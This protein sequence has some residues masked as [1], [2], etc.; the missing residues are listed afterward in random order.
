[1]IAIL[2]ITSMFVSWAGG[3]LIIGFDLRTTL[4]WLAFLILGPLLV[5]VFAAV[6]EAQKGKRDTATAKSR[7]RRSRIPPDRVTRERDPLPRAAR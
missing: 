4:V 6:A 2:W 5:W 1:M 7:A 3:T